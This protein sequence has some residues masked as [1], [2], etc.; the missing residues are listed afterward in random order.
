VPFLADSDVRRIY[1][2]A[3]LTSEVD[4]CRAFG[5]RPTLR[6]EPESDAGIGERL[7]ILAERHTLKDNGAKGVTEESIARVVAADNKLLIY[8]TSYVAAK[9]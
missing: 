6:I 5:K 7:I 3:T 9:K 1:L 2:S 8:V 4:F